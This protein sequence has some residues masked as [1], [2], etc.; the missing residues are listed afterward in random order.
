[1]LEFTMAT[2]KKETKK[3]ATQKSEISDATKSKTAPAS[4]TEKKKVTKKKAVKKTET[5]SAKSKL[6]ELKAK[7][8]ALEGKVEEEKKLDIKGEVSGKKEEKDDGLVPIEDYL[9][10]SIHLGIRVIT[11][12][13]RKYVY[14]RRADGLAVFDTAMLD[15]KIKEGAKFLAKYAPEDIVI[16]CKREAGW[17]AVK[18]FANTFGIKTFTKKYPAGTLTNPNLEDFFEKELVF[19]CDPWLDKNALRDSNKIKIPVMSL[20]DT[21]NYTRGIEQVIPGN[22]KSSKSLGIIF[23]LLTKLYIENRKLDIEAPALEEF[24]DDWENLIPPK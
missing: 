20:C 8:K 13:M 23:Y 2:E 5:A 24:V 3:K 16:I 12:D 9:K 14:R 1:M 10:S 21:N 17:K 6:E 11:P 4:G 19:I 22:N 15:N 18:K 7:A